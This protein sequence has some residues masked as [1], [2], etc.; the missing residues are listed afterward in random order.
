MKK[1]R[2]RLFDADVRVAIENAVVSVVT[3]HFDCPGCKKRGFRRHGVHFD[4]EFR[5]GSCDLSWEPGKTVLMVEFNAD[6]AKSSVDAP[7]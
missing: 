2:R 5:C 7:A 3:P 4:H 1:R 6:V